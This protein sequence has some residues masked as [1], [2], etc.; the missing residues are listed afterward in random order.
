MRMETSL[1]LYSKIVMKKKDFFELNDQR[2]KN[3][4]SKIGIEMEM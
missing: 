3:N 2:T 1:F 4:I